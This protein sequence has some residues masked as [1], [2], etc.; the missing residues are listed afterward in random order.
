[1]RL[2]I[3]ILFTN[4]SAHA[5]LTIFDVQRNLPL[6]NGEKI[7]HDYYVDGGTESGLTKGM[8]LTVQRRLPLY[9]YY[10]SRSVGDLQ[11]SI[12]RVKVMD[13]QDGLAVVRTLDEISREDVPLS[14]DNFIMIGDHLDV[15]AVVAVA[16]PA[17]ALVTPPAAVAPPAP[18]VKAAAKP[19]G[20][21]VVNSVSVQADEA[22]IAEP[23][24]TPAPAPKPA[25][26]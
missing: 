12:A 19:A 15:R 3:V 9:D 18:E 14:D 8:V 25:A 1:M 26:Q 2:M 22:K 21:I 10:R 6:A 24:P 16:D 17:P 23:V 11:T 13:A 7:F 20:Q 5:E 4:I